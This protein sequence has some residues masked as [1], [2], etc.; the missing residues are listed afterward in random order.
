MSRT[1]TIGAFLAATLTTV[2]AAL[3]LGIPASAGTSNVGVGFNAPSISGFPGDFSGGSVVLTGGGAYD[4]TTASNAEPEAAFVHSSGGF[5]CLDTVAQGLLKGCLAGQGVRWDTEGLLARTRF[6]C[7][8]AA[9]EP[10]KSA[11]TD[12]HT[13][14]LVSD[15][16]RAGDGN[17][18][19]F[20]GVQVILADHDLAPDIEGI[21]NVWIQ[22]V[23]CGTA[24]INFSS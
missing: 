18:A 22:Q 17:D 20:K 10:A 1:I 23:G 12:A 4:P 7:T 16:Y 19:S 11:T 8:G 15:F 14:V 2:A 6:K 21:Q 5:R 9:N 24:K 3:L 13:A